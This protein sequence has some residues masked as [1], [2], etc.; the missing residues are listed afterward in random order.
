MRLLSFFL[1][2]VS[3]KLTAIDRLLD[4]YSKTEESETMMGT[5]HS[6]NFASEIGFT[7][8]SFVW[9]AD[10]DGSLTPSTRKF[11]LQVK[12]ELL[13]KQGAI[14]L[15]VGPTGSGKTSLLVAL[16]GASRRTVNPQGTDMDAQAKCIL[17]Q[18]PLE[19]GIISREKRVSRTLRRSH[20]FR[21]RPSKYTDLLPWYAIADIVCF[22]VLGQHPIWLPLRRRALQEGPP[23]VRF[24][25]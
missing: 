3:D 5:A 7:D 15:I 4:A 8:A 9:S 21:T 25:A 22:S 17:C 20:G 11:V 16:L 23:S 24:R 1:A 19:H 6:A 18:W 12:D 13:F 2:P 14:N 10:V